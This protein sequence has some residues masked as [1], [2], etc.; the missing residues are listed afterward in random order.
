MT[1]PSSTQTELKR[2]QFRRKRYFLIAAI[3]S[4]VLIFL[5]ELALTDWKD[6][7]QV[8]DFARTIFGGIIITTLILYLEKTI[9]WEKQESKQENESFKADLP[10]KQELKDGIQE[11]R[12][13]LSSQFQSFNTKQDINNQGIR[14]AQ[15]QVSGLRQDLQNKAQEIK[16]AVERVWS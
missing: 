12:N 15:E 13:D 16:Q 5:I 3:V 10:L 7:P 8:K 2:K 14:A 6:L 4:G 1:I 11:I 9:E